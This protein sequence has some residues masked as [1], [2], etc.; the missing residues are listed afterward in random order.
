MQVVLHDEEIIAD[1][2]QLSRLRQAMWNS[3]RAEILRLAAAIKLCQPVLDLLTSRNT[4]GG[5]TRSL[6]HKNPSWPGV[7]WTVGDKKPFTI[8]NL[9]DLA[10]VL[11]EE[12]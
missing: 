1:P 4:G 2:D 3:D 11:L 10:K 8:K 9:L 12:R 6:C 7:K 5:W